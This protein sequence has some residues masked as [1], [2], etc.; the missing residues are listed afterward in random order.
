[1]KVLYVNQT[2]QISGAERSLLSLLSGLPHG[3]TP[4][5]ACPRGPLATEAAALGVEVRPIAGTHASFRLH[6]RHTARGLV[7]MAL[8]VRAVCQLAQ[9]VRPDLV[10]ANTTRAGLITVAASR[11]GAPPSVVHVRDWVPKGRVADR[12]LDCIARGAAG[13]LVNSRYVG[14]QFTRMPP[15]TVFRVIDNPVDLHRF[16][17]A[18]LDRASAQA[19]LGLAPENITLAVM[20]QLTPWKGQDDA[21]KALAHLA[22]RH[23]A[24]RLLVVGSSKFSGRGTRFDNVAYA[25]RLEPLA[26]ELGVADKVLFLGER[27]D[28]PHILRAAD[29]LLV[30]SWREAFGRI[31]AEGMA[32]GLPVVATEVGGPAE[33]VEDGASGVLVPPRRADLLASALEPLVEEEGLRRR[34]GLRG[35]ELA[36]ERFAVPR[37]VEQV[38]DSYLEV[39]RAPPLPLG[40]QGTTQPWL[41]STWIT[42]FWITRFAAR[43]RLL[44]IRGE[45]VRSGLPRT[46]HDEEAD[47]ARSSSSEIPDG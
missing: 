34:M 47:R 16:N 1:M 20:A 37:H 32:M 23:E 36:L 15:A 46:R 8:S 44:L 2:A 11:L 38:M 42:R 25:N 12:T 33:I 24:L 21:I 5:L 13:V 17:P 43:L 14:G 28:I 4:V 29:I 7:D 45:L 41:A 19:A 6:P 40:S 35:R 10:H 26:R 22:A 9:A 39:L 30:P 27:S 3:V 18:I 31:V